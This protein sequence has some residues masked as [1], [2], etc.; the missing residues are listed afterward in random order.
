VKFLNICCFQA[1]YFK[2]NATDNKPLIINKIAMQKKI[3]QA[4]N[5]AFWQDAYEIS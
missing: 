1:A 5:I 2:S 4:R 3:N